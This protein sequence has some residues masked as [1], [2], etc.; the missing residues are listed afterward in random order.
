MDWLFILFILLILGV[1]LACAMILFKLNQAVI[2]KNAYK[3]QYDHALNELHDLKE[4][5]AI[6]NRE[7]QQT[8]A[9]LIAKNQAFD[10]L[11]AYNKQ[12]EAKQ[13]SDRDLFLQQAKQSVMEAG[14]TL[15][16]KLLHDHREE[17]KQS[18][19]EAE[20]RVQK[21]HPIHVGKI[22]RFGS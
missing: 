22:A 14:Q 3:I 10:D 13:K 7:Y 8:H 20:E 4:K 9:N 11:I 5:H 19:R 1:G 6:L 21:S 16:S 17:N 15:S 18:R 12:A 2:G